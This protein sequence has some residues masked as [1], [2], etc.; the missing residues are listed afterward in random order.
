MLGMR[1]R[2]EAGDYVA[3]VSKTRSDAWD[4][5]L[6]MHPGV[7]HPKDRRVMEHHFLMVEAACAGL[8]VGLSPKVVATDDV[9]RGRLIAPRGFEADGSHYGLIARSDTARS[10]EAT[11]LSEWIETTCGS[12]SSI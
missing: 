2:F 9:D 6:A 1:D 10:T 8:G 12:L 11:T 3:L 4:D 7:P 5:W